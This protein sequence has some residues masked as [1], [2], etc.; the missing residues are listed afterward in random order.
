[1][2]QFE[3]PSGRSYGLM[4]ELNYMQEEDIRL[5]ATRSRSSNAWKRHGD[6]A[7]R[8][9]STLMLAAKRIQI[10]D[11]GSRKLYFLTS[12][13]LRSYVHHFQ[14]DAFI[15]IGEK[16]CAVVEE[17]NGFNKLSCITNIYIYIYN[18]ASSG[19]Y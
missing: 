18:Y 5:E 8:M 6:L 19:L 10:E 13:L 3:S 12:R 9:S 17:V 16:C 7:E 1:M 4:G 15:E 14:E 11:L 2:Q